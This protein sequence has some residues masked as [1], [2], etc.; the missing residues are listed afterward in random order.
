[1][2]MFSIAS[3]ATSGENRFL[4]HSTKKWLTAA[5]TRREITKGLRE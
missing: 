3:L 4:A 5:H 2:I 1:M